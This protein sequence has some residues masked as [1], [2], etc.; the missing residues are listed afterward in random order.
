[1]P[2][3]YIDLPSFIAD[4][5]FQ[6][7]DLPGQHEALNKAFAYN[8]GIFGKQVEPLLATE[9]GRAVPGA[10]KTMGFAF[11]EARRRVT[12][13]WTSNKIADYAAAND[14]DPVAVRERVMSHAQG[15]DSGELLSPEEADIANQL[16][17]AQYDVMQRY[18]L[19]H[20]EQG[21]R[22][23]RF[24]IGAPEGTPVAAG[25][26]FRLNG[27]SYFNL[28]FDADEEGQPY[29]DPSKRKPFVFK[30]PEV[31]GAGNT[32]Y[33]RTD[34]NL[35][36]KIEKL[37][38]EADR[39]EKPVEQGALS[40][41][42]SVLGTDQNATSLHADAVKDDMVKS[43]RDRAQA[44]K[45]KRDRY[46][47]GWQGYTEMMADMA[48]AHIKKD[49]NLL[50]HVPRPDSPLVQLTGDAGLGVM[51]TYLGTAAGAQYLTGFEEA[52]KDTMETQKTVELARESMGMGMQHF[53]GSVLDNIATE[54]PAE[55]LQTYTDLAVGGMI[56]RG[57]RA[58]LSPLARVAARRVGISAG[59]G[60][61]GEAIGQAAKNKAVE[62]AKR[63]IYGKLDKFGQAI[64][65]SAPGAL[66]EASGVI[67]KVAEA[68]EMFEQAKSLESKLAEIPADSVEFAEARLQIETEAKSLRERAQ[69]IHEGAAYAFYSTMA[70]TMITDTYGFERLL[71]VGGR[72]LSKAGAVEAV[73]K[74]LGKAGVSD[75]AIDA[76]ADALHTSLENVAGELMASSGIQNVVDRLKNGTIEGVTEVL[77]GVLNNAAMKTFVD[78]HQEIFQG[79]EALTE[80]GVGFIVSAVLTHIS[81][82]VEPHHVQ[83]ALRDAADRTNAA[84]R[85]LSRLDKSLQNAE[86]GKGIEGFGRT[87]PPQDVVKQKGDRFV[88]ED[89]KDVVSQALPMGAFGALTFQTREQAEE[90]AK[91][92]WRTA[93]EAMV[94]E[95]FG[96]R[97]QTGTGKDLDSDENRAAS[98]REIDAL[99]GTT[100]IMANA[101]AAGG[102]YSTETFYAA[103]LQSYAAYKPSAIDQAQQSA[104]GEAAKMLADNEQVPEEIRAAINAHIK[105][106]E[107]GL[108]KS[109]EAAAL[110]ESLAGR[111][112]SQS[113][114]S[115]QSRVFTMNQADEGS[116]TDAFVGIQR[117]GESDMTIEPIR[118]DKGNIVDTQIT[119][120]NPAKIVEKYN[121]AS[122][123]D[124][125]RRKAG[126]GSPASNALWTA[127][128][129]HHFSI[130]SQGQAGS[131]TQRQEWIKEAGK[132]ASEDVKNSRRERS[133][134]PAGVRLSSPK[135]THEADHVKAAAATKFIGRGS[136]GSTPN[137]NAEAFGKTHANS[138]SYTAKDVVFVSAEGQ[139]QGRQAPDLAEVTKAAKAGATII[140][141]NPTNR[142]RPHNT[143]E[144]EVADHLRALG[145]HESSTRDMSVWTRTKLETTA[146]VDSDAQSITMKDS[147]GNAIPGTPTIPVMAMYQGYS[148]T[149]RST[150]DAI[151]TGHRSATTRGGKSFLEGSVI[152][153][154]NPSNPN[155]GVFAVVRTSQTL[156]EIMRGAANEEKRKK[157]IERL[158]QR[159]GYTAKEFENK[160]M[161]KPGW[162]TKKHTTFQAV[163]PDYARIRQEID[164]AMFSDWIK[165]V[166]SGKKSTG[167][168]FKNLSANLLGSRIDEIDKFSQTAEKPIPT[169]QVSYD[170]VRAEAENNKTVASML[171]HVAGLATIANIGDMSTIGGHFDAFK[172]KAITL[173][174]YINAVRD[175]AMT[176]IANRAGS[177]TG[178]AMLARFHDGEVVTQTNMG[179][180]ELGAT[181]AA[182]RRERW[183]KHNRYLSAL[184][185]GE[186]G[187][188]YAPLGEVGS[189]TGEVRYAKE[190][191]EEGDF[192]L[193]QWNDQNMRKSG[194]QIVFAGKFAAEA[195]QKSV[196]VA[197]DETG[198]HRFIVKRLYNGRPM[199]F[200]A[201][202]M[203]DGIKGWATAD[204]RQAMMG[205]FLFASDSI[206]KDMNIAKFFSRWDQIVSGGVDNVPDAL[207]AIPNWRQLIRGWT[208][209]I[210]GGG[211]V[212]K[213]DAAVRR[214]AMLDGA[215]AEIQQ[216]TTVDFNRPLP[217]Q[218]G[219]RAPFVQRQEGEDAIDPGSPSGGKDFR[220]F[221]D[222]FERGLSVT[223]PNRLGGFMEAITA[224]EMGE[225][226]VD[227]V[228]AGDIAA[229]LADAWGANFQAPKESG[230]FGIQKE[231][232]GDGASAKSVDESLTK[233]D[234]GAASESI[235][236][237]I[238]KNATGVS[239]ETLTAE[240]IVSDFHGKFGFN[241]RHVELIVA[242]LS[243]ATASK[244][245]IDKINR[246]LSE[247]ETAENRELFD[248]LRKEVQSYEMAMIAE[249]ASF[250]EKSLP[251]RMM[252]ELVGTLWWQGRVKPLKDTYSALGFS[253]RATPQQ[254]EEFVNQI[255]AT[256]G[257]PDIAE[258]FQAVYSD[259]SGAATDSADYRAKLMEEA[260]RQLEGAEAG[261][262]GAMIVIMALD[263]LEKEDARRE[264][265]AGKKVT[266]EIY[267]IMKRMGI[268]KAVW[269]SLMP[270]GFTVP[271]AGS[272]IIDPSDEDVDFNDMAS[273]NKRVPEAD[274]ATNRAAPAVLHVK[275]EPNRI[276]PEVMTK[277][278]QGAAF[279]TGKQYSPKVKFDKDGD[280]VDEELSMDG[281]IDY[282][283]PLDSK[284][285]NDFVKF[286]RAAP[287]LVMEM[288]K[289]SGANT[290]P[291]ADIIKKAIASIEIPSAEAVIGFAIGKP[292][293]AN[294]ALY[295]ISRAMRKAANTITKIGTEEA[296]NVAQ[297]VR[298]AGA[299][300]WMYDDRGYKA[301]QESERSDEKVDPNEPEPPVSEENVVFGLDIMSS[302]TE[303]GIQVADLVNLVQND[304]T[305]AEKKTFWKKLISGSSAMRDQWYGLAD[306]LAKIGN[307]G[308]IITQDPMASTSHE[309]A[310]VQLYREGWKP[311]ASERPA[312]FQQD[313]NRG[314]KRGQIKLFD[315]GL[316]TISFTRHATVST[317]IH[318][319]THWMNRVVSE[320]GKPLLQ[321]MLGDNG[322]TELMDYA[323]DGGKLNPASK[324]GFAEIEERIAYGIERYFS[325]VGEN[326]N[327]GAI[328]A[329]PVATLGKV[330]RNVWMQIYRNS[331][332]N[333]PPNVRAAFDAVFLPS[334]ANEALTGLT[335]KIRKHKNEMLT[336]D[337]LIAQ[338][339]GQEQTPNVKGRITKAVNRRY[340]AARAIVEL[341]RQSQENEALAKELSEAEKA[342]EKN[343]LKPENLSRIRAARLNYAVG[344]SFTSPVDMSSKEGVVEFVTKAF[345]PDAD[346]KAIYDALRVVDKEA[347]MKALGR[348]MPL[349]FPLVAAT[350][351][352]T[353]ADDLGTVLM[354]TDPNG[355]YDEAAEMVNEVPEDLRSS[356]P[357]MTT[358]DKDGT[359]LFSYTPRAQPTHIFMGGASWARRAYENS[360][361]TKNPI[362]AFARAIYRMGSLIKGRGMAPKALFNALTRSL[363]GRDAAEGEALR[364]QAEM[365]LM[366]AKEAAAAGLNPA[367]RGRRRR[368]LNQ[369][370]NTAMSHPDSQERANALLKLNGTG[371][372]IAA[373][374]ARDMIDRFM[375]ELIDEGIIFGPMEL[376]WKSKMGFFMH[377]AYMLRGGTADGQKTW[378]QNA[379]GGKLWDDAVK[380]LATD[381]GISV[382]NASILLDELLKVVESNHG[383]KGVFSGDLLSSEA[384]VMMRDPARRLDAFYVATSEA[385]RRST[386]KNKVSPYQVMAEL[387][388]MVDDERQARTPAWA[389]SIYSGT[390]FAKDI[391]GDVAKAIGLQEE[392]QVQFM[393]A[394][395]T[396]NSA[397]SRHRAEAA[398]RDAGIK[399]GWIRRANDKN[400]TK[401]LSA[402]FT[403]G[404]TADAANTPAE[405]MRMGALSG[406]ASTPE[407]VEWWNSVVNHE[408]EP[409]HVNA[410]VALMGTINGVW[411][412][413]HTILSGGTSFVNAMSS[414]M[415]GFATGHFINGYGDAAKM[416]LAHEFGHR[417]V[418]KSIMGQANIDH[419]RASFDELVKTGEVEAGTLNDI[420]DLFRHTPQLMSAVSADLLTRPGSSDAVNE[421]ARMGKSAINKVKQTAVGIYRY[422]DSYFKMASMLAESESLQAAFPNLSA[423]EI[424][425]MAA[426]RTGRAMF[427]FRREPHWMRS[428]KR[429]VPGVGVLFSY[430]WGITRAYMN[431]LQIAASDIYEGARRAKA[432]EQGGSQQ[433][434]MGLKR[435]GGMA[436]TSMLA[437][438]VIAP[439]IN[440]MFGWDDER[441]KAARQML[442]EWDRDG[443]II[444]QDD[445]KGDGSPVRYVN[446]GRY[447]PFLITTNSGKHFAALVGGVVANAAAGNIEG[448]NKAI[449]EH[450]WSSV[451]RILD[452]FLA[453]S[454]SMALA[455]ALIH[456]DL[457]TP[458]MNTMEV[459]TAMAARVAKDF[460]PG[461][462]TDLSKAGIIHNRYLDMLGFRAKTGADGKELAAHQ[463]A[464]YMLGYKYGIMDPSGGIVTTAGKN[465]MV[466]ADSKRRLAQLLAE[467]DPMS[468]DEIMK[469]IQRTKTHCDVAS[470]NIAT[471]IEA[472]KT[473]GLRTED[474]IKA[475]STAKVQV[476]PHVGSSITRQQIASSLVGSWRGP[477]KF[478]LSTLIN[479]KKSTEKSDPA[480]LE[481][482]KQA[483]KAG[484]IVFESGR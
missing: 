441:D 377:R 150:Y 319:M 143:G 438:T 215:I 54:L 264:R 385:K 483:V 207:R 293:P 159:E 233:D 465:L 174:Q 374:K 287:D 92:R 250:G 217:S 188:F 268:Q 209:F 355:A 375:Q 193:T 230:F 479:I 97:A 86:I 197:V 409:Q 299:L 131:E 100:R 227:E 365:E 357:R 124:V 296:Q 440:G 335:A 212:N 310:L 390:V 55:L 12:E 67:S 75:T 161:G 249:G 471:V 127:R 348:H 114:G 158:A 62:R 31:E 199:W 424:R 324:S 337:S 416:V 417:S 50:S 393:N 147:D 48:T 456:G 13:Q 295:S 466:A 181:E 190:A 349:G 301:K 5:R 272:N 191:L 455:T 243:D 389:D 167:E 102:D 411:A 126:I 117:G 184:Q 107:P 229:D 173:G 458:S 25:E 442:P 428:F 89:P 52:S 218:V 68:D 42:F 29:Q 163:S 454:E 343:P 274:K 399:E 305:L 15:V 382:E 205:F 370:I 396:M 420:L 326:A 51:S 2:E 271:S 27:S 353:A 113:G 87:L 192:I 106:K 467:S 239:G 241:A 431:G 478:S 285:A 145:Y 176:E 109:P 317:F 60:A 77:Q 260:S 360:A 94:R 298:S 72:K 462:I 85:E 273:G 439:L 258:A 162:E 17:S 432:G 237:T 101:S 445:Y 99:I 44:A 387:R 322:Y 381:K 195:N 427:S 426:E 257:R 19:P 47:N 140:T 330:I 429:A 463:K 170:D 267:T 63:F 400:R 165:N 384:V 288:I 198:R 315:A 345:G 340:K 24:A 153:I 105:A 223:P 74:H 331:D 425:A 103:H 172:N 388:E 408:F 28:V 234:G 279:M 457:K 313:P 22:Q 362:I 194:A 354:A 83:K 448:A 254:I 435:A 232:K 146:E 4:P 206:G 136:P 79:D 244:E 70:I 474:V 289:R 437:Q 66:E 379:R 383:G 73:R 414:M 224:E 179:Q 278:Y 452:P 366:V 185:M 219:S 350:G 186:D 403:P 311:E 470:Q 259:L 238:L 376:A 361:D 369:I 472:A 231:E 110:I 398:V 202:Q 120:I 104:F 373:L 255:S 240:D 142:A 280:P 139:R 221:F 80:F 372:D 460:T 226:L 378:A 35:R 135:G 358:T 469:A 262:P 436:L 123:S 281:A 309:E 180:I 88:I 302:V 406:Y 204:D 473:L 148:A 154:Q 318:E 477:I 347:A 430:G 391:R 320:S 423:E 476:I 290:K 449:E 321:T 276:S 33:E 304:A 325:M 155:K 43:L 300:S 160:V 156:G 78:E 444:Y 484:L 368:E 164:A 312:L 111:L 277:V 419:F 30:V 9:E 306:M 108:P 41:F 415:T 125:A 14:M 20:E 292:G 386:K 367:A 134:A 71:N 291:F 213:Q 307:D 328:P 222:S 225:Q 265:R 401:H 214:R 121:Q 201:T 59:A 356:L 178:A 144:R 275:H 8:E 132:R 157:L 446:I 96:K 36:I 169:G 256:M 397:L 211:V 45:E 98:K 253:E 196:V 481:I 395:R 344:A 252:R 468:S 151:L 203:S 461:T 116:A 297:A 61:V 333:I 3:N 334:A 200:E 119:R 284:S 129:R 359:L 64:I 6:E 314:V 91:T 11:K 482:L 394:I 248:S 235:L 220:D 453:E 339:Q 65:S 95:D 166:V 261:E 1:M 371:I 342:F 480:R 10:V 168:R 84:D 90:F 422:G 269:R 407:V 323:T 53:R 433:L 351:E 327:M 56:L 286:M 443:V 316:P 40:K 346:I 81:K 21:G 336:E 251:E 137:A 341:K 208:N 128:A 118:D 447:L 451:K 49:D 133:D 247:E 26:T 329:G 112:V 245:R 263:L 236:L 283:A 130:L 177:A 332:Y 270:D 16:V 475:M 410:I 76:A 413:S 380:Q 308:A 464:A 152:F 338:L 418:T 69:K 138:G 32:L 171:D 149:G 412:V 23:A 37:E 450:A 266:T 404:G 364:I 34:N 216:S 82:G 434:A 303:N 39:L 182:A 246:A 294:T 210:S 189:N 18:D 58:S 57:A 187:L 282:G 183:R 405:A 421:V 363:G 175:S 115:Q 122:P 242:A 402:L 392:P 46:A 93:F 459:I 38:A 352:G 7:K 228:S 141:D